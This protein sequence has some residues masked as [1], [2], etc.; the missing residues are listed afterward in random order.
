MG[1]LTKNISRHEL[2]CNCGK[3]DY[4]TM[5]FETINVVQEACDYFAKK[6]GVAKVTL[7][8]N[9]AHRCFPYNRAVGSNDASQHPRGN[10]MDIKISGVSPK[11][12]YLFLDKKYPDK[13]G[14]GCYSTFT[15]IDTRR[16]KARWGY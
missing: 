10:A 13:Y 4:Q 12:L 2:R 8:I 15:H 16:T 1:D 7:S 9:S 11:E 6:Q 14:I 5:D 3:C